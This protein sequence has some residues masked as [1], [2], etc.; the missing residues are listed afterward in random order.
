MPRQTLAEVIRFV[1]RRASREVFEGG[2]QP[3]AERSGTA[4]QPLRLC[5]TD[6]E[7]MEVATDL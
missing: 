2:V 4:N 3:A 1:A 7:I 5:G 6:D